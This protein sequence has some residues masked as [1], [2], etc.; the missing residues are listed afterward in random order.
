MQTSTHDSNA[1]VVRPQR[2]SDSSWTGALNYAEAVSSE[3]TQ[4]DRLWIV[5]GLDEAHDVYRL[6]ASD[7]EKIV[8][9][10]GQRS[11]V[12]AAERDVVTAW[13]RV[14]IDVRLVAASDRDLSSKAQSGSF[15][16]DLLAL[17]ALG[18]RAAPVEVGL[19]EIDQPVETEFERR[20]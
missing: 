19:L 5:P 18:Q 11:D 13:G 3:S 7:F 9:L 14:P 1:S 6:V 20:A 16:E 4:T 15:H 10:A 8:D 2:V 12:E 17:L